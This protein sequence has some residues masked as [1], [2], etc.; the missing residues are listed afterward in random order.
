MLSLHNILSP[1]WVWLLQVSL[2]S[3]ALLL[4][5]SWAL[6]TQESLDTNYQGQI[7]RAFLGTS[8]AGLLSTIFFI[9]MYSKN[10]C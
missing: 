8:Q 2:S 6:H 10:M 1:P 9:D 7:G 4:M 3:P 5:I